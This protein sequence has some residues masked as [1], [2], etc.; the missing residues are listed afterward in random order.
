MI[1]LALFRLREELHARDVDAALV[2]TVHDEI[3]VE[4]EES[5]AL[6]VQELVEKVMRAA[7]EYYVKSVPVDVE[8]AIADCWS[9]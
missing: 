5:I 6:E 4:C 3:V 2:N 9:K 8:S 7:G 1:K